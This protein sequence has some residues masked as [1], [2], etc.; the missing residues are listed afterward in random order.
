MSDRRADLNRRL[1]EADAAL[2][3]AAV[4][5]K[6]ARDR[7]REAERLYREAR[8]AYGEAYRAVRAESAA[9]PAPAGL[10]LDALEREAGA[11]GAA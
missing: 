10:D 6:D 9:P 2:T 5:Q 4:N 7:A 11:I 1:S 3:V 8:A